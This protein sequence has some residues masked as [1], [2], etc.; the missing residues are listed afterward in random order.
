[1]TLGESIVFKEVTQRFQG[2]FS[3]IEN[4]EQ[5]KI[6]IEKIQNIFKRDGFIKV[7]VDT[8]NNRTLTQNAALHVYFKNVSQ[9]LNDQNMSVRKTLRED[10]EMDWTPNLVKELLWKPI[11]EIVLG[12]KSTT[13]LEKKDP[14]HVYDILHRKLTEWGVNVPFPSVE[15]IGDADYEYENTKV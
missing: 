4:E 8:K 6:A 15:N 11:Q 7:K 12:T 10:F 3:C 14:S 13:K 5:L 9:G 1:M 2:E